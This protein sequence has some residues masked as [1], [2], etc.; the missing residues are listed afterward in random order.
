MKK[1]LFLFLCFPLVVFAADQWD[2][3][4][5]TAAGTGGLS[6]GP[7][8]DLTE[9]GAPVAGDFLLCEES[10]GA[11]RKCD[12]GDLPSAAENVRIVWRV[13]NSVSPLESSTDD[14]ACW[15]TTEALTLSEITASVN[16]QGSTSGQMTVDVNE[17][18]T[19]IMSTNKLDILYTATV[20]DGTAALSDTAIA[21]GAL[22]CA[23]IDGVSGGATEL[24]LTIIL[25]VSY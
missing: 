9:E 5:R 18:G 24:G 19:T 3:V 21:S 22:L 14:L 2:I 11:L 7:I 12:V 8:T 10:G 23:Q 15:R 16:T 20:D 17:A 6:S 4:Y 25:E 1:L 13:T